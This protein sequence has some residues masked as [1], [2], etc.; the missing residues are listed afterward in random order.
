MDLNLKNKIAVVVA[1]SRGLGKATALALAQEGCTLAVCSRRKDT[2]EKT[3]SEIQ[4]ATKSKI[5]ASAV[6]ITNPQDISR[7]ASEVE[8]AYGHI[9]ILVNNSGGP[10]PGTFDDLRE[11][12]FLKATEL[13]LLNVVRTTKAFLPLIRK[14]K[15]GG[16]I[17]TITST[18]VREPIPNLILSNTLR[19][20][21]TGWS[22]TLAKE[23][24]P[25][26]I[27][28]NGIAPGLIQTER[29][30][31]LIAARAA[32]T[33]DSEQAVKA[34]MLEKLPLGRMGTPQEIASAI[35]F[36]ASDR[37]SYISGTTLYVDGAAMNSVT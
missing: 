23:L 36:L 34:E 21:V 16:R 31:E 30:D 37:A 24:A 8:S 20:A 11:E 19:A 10:I 28:V 2:I 32:K 25:E 3:A 35:T 5:Y 26:N 17:I 22:K 7:F 14:N 12:D 1:S 6:D 27:L 4:L 29:I 13:L 33:G 18:S 9:D 15:K